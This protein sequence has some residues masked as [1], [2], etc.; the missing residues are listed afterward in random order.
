VEDSDPEDALSDPVFESTTS[1]SE[2]IV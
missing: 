2:I 1:S